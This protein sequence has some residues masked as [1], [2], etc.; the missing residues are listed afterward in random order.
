MLKKIFLQSLVGATAVGSALTV[1]VVATPAAVTSAPAI[2]NVACT[3]PYQGSETTTTKVS[4]RP[5]VG[6]YGGPAK[7]FATVTSD[8][9][10]PTGSVRFT[11]GG[12][13]WDVRLT[14]GTASVALPRGLRAQTTYTVHGQY[15]PGCS[16]FQRSAG[17]GYYTVQKA[18]TQT[19]AT[20][21]N[22]K[23]GTHPRVRVTVSS[24]Y[25]TPVGSVRITVLKRG[26]VVASK[27]R[28][29]RSGHAFASF[30][31]LRVGRYS[32]VAVYLG[33]HNFDRSSDA[34]V[35]RVTR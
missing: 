33:A 6:I 30:R 1:S 18:P 17:T 12:R 2:R 35:F 28:S 19:L 31:T 5:A 7:A 13:H 27:V 15:R 3:V 10:T 22:V 29:L 32:A 26:H 24:T 14:S 25:R 4:V 16:I 34:D 9:G 23:R 8:N 21:P 11:L 20:A